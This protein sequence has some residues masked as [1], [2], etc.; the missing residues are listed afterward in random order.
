MKNAS[1]FMLRRFAPAALALVMLLSALLAS[2]GETVVNNGDDTSAP[3][4]STV[5]EAAS[6]EVET[7]VSDD[8]PEGT[9]FGGATV[10]M[11]YWEDVENQEYFAEEERGA[12]VND[13][14]FARN[15]RVSER[16]KI[17]FE[18]TPTKGN[19]SH[20]NNY[21]DYVKKNVNGG[22]DP[23]DII[24]AYSRSMGLCAYNGL[25]SPI[26]DHPVV[27]LSKPWWP[28]S[29][30]STSTIG[31]K[32]YFV[33]GDISTNLLYMM[34]VVFYN[35][36]LM[37]DNN[38]ED[39]YAAFDDGSWTLE[40]F[41]SLVSGMYSDTDG[42]GNVTQGDQFGLVDLALHTDA[43]LFGSGLSGIDTSSG[44]LALSDEFAGEKTATLVEKIQGLFAG[45]DA[46]IM[47]S[48]SEYKPIFADGRSLFVV[49]RAD[50]A[51]YDL[52][53][54]DF[55]M[56]VLPVPKYDENQERYLTAVGNPFSLYAIPVNAPEK[57][58]SATVIEAL[59]SESY[60]TLVPAV[61]ELT[62]KT[63]YAE[64]ADDAVVYD[65]VRNGCVFDLC[66]IF[67]NVFGSSQAPDSLF[68]SAIKGTSSWSSVFGPAKKAVQNTIK[69]INK[70]F[71]LD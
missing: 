45:D 48:N 18:F 62:M 10:S 29:L 5:T 44:K 60:R 8:I 51:I 57:E 32:V 24:S 53:E 9:E 37:E 67:W 35:K 6:A 16:L 58:M 30:V 59:A 34:Y 7:E 23:F 68:E 20:A 70:A 1:S 15:T 22:T 40:L 14:I 31:G 55:E 36:D 39:P 38:R 63:K 52:N 27:N 21:L 11:L 12:L 61:F 69:K 65:T 19:S 4:Q 56:G 33:S 3:A 2:C 66:R 42:S 26:T 28:G 47:G 71:E 17:S 43:F 46:Q 25:T 50:I 13:A 49:D 64:A 41:I 54:K